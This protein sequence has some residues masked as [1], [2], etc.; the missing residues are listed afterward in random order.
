M[1][2]STLLSSTLLILVTLREQSMQ[3]CA[4]L[5]DESKME[6]TTVCTARSVTRRHPPLFSRDYATTSLL[7]FD[8]EIG[9]LNQSYY[10]FILCHLRPRK[11]DSVTSTTDPLSSR[12]SLILKSDRYHMKYDRMIQF[13]D[14]HVLKWVIPCCNVTLRHIFLFLY[15]LLFDFP[16]Q[17]IIVK[18]TV[19]SAP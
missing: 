2:S 14:I 15:P 3:M 6:A 16:R 1:T 5:I 11:Y 18:N 13:A 10:F 17:K 9:R 12:V 19:I 4:S 8:T 7:I